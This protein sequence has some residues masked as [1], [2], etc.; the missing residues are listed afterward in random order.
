[1]KTLITAFAFGIL[2]GSPALVQPAN[3]APP[4]DD[5]RM[6]AL[7][8]C[9]ARARKYIEHT[10]GDVEIYTYRACMTE[11]GQQE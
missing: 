3:A 4:T 11:H 8:E 1:M 9:N 5:A 7:Q 10:W 2:F 6:K